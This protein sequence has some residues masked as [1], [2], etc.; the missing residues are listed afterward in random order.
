VN[1][2]LSRVNLVIEFLY[3][4]L[5]IVGLSRRVS[6]LPFMTDRTTGAK[7]RT[8]RRLPVD[9]SEKSYRPSH[10]PSATAQRS[11]Y[12][13]RP[14]TGRDYSEE[15]LEGESVEVAEGRLPSEGE[16][17]GYTLEVADRRLVEEEEL[18][19]G[20]EGKGTEVSEKV[21]AK[22]VDQGTGSE[23]MMF[24][25]F[26]EEKEERRSG[27]CRREEECRGKKEIGVSGVNAGV[28]E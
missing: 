9:K 5:L 17:L 4:F 16:E 12:L 27:I 6:A 21:M 11:P 10:I 23:M 25:K 22:G 26:M 28:E 2:L 8:T 3:F 18:E 19:S 20:I 24:L 15:E 7:G 1:L 14:R 13:S